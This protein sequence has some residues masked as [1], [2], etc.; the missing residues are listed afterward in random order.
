MCLPLLRE[1]MVISVRFLFKHSESPL[2][3]LKMQSYLKVL[4]ARS[5]NL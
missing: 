2:H 4:Y 1:K 5:V 3:E